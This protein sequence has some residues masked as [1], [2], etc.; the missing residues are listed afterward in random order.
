M[1]T[2]AHLS[3][4]TEAL[5]IALIICWDRIVWP[6]SSARPATGGCGR[7]HEVQRTAATPALSKFERLGSPGIYLSG[8]HCLADCSKGL[9][10][11]PFAPLTRVVYQRNRVGCPKGR[12]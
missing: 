1:L 5:L 2:T 9:G 3:S 12:G 4:A 6:A 11:V 7:L 8:F 10:S